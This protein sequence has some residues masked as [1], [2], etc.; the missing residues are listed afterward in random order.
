MY[1]K[2]KIA[3]EKAFRTTSASFIRDNR[4]SLEPHEIAKIRAGK[5]VCG[6]GG[7]A[8]RWCIWKPQ[9]KRRK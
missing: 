8:T 2:L 9:A 1:L 6:G 4:D 5:R 3:G 7:A